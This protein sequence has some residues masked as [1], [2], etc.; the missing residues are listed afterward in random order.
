M[1]LIKKETLKN[2]IKAVWI[3]SLTE[4]QPDI[5]EGLEQAMAAERNERARQYLDIIIQNA[6]IATQNG[7]VICQDTG[8]PTFYVRTSL[9]FPYQDSIQDAFDEAMRELTLKEFPMRSM[10][11]NPL[12][13]EERGDN[14]GKTCPSFTLNWSPGWITWR[15]WRRPKG[16]AAVCGAYDRPSALGGG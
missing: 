15:L 3:R 4:I 2:A 6:R 12:T 1:S 5:L 9:G 14:T 7:T 8:V 16:R 11:V 13:R 10:V